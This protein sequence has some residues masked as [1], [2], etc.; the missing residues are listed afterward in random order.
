MAGGLCTQMGMEGGLYKQR[1]Q[2]D[3]AEAPQVGKARREARNRD[4][5]KDVTGDVVPWGRTVSAWK[6]EG[7]Q[8]PGGPL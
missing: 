4:G 6:G 2:G 7:R 8:G 1:R 3:G 5:G